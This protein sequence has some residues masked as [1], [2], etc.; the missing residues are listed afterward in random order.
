MP[1][2]SESVIKCPTFFL[3]FRHGSQAGTCPALRVDPDSLASCVSEADEDGARDD[4]R[5]RDD[6]GCWGAI[7]LSCYAET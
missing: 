5:L 3:R 1:Y 4:F 6:G 2:N 7:M